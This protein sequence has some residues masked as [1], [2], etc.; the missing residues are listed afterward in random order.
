MNEKELK[1]LETVLNHPP[2]PGDIEQIEMAKDTFGYAFGSL[3]LLWCVMKDGGYILLPT[4][5]DWKTAER[6]ES[7]EENMWIRGVPLPV[8]T[9]V[10]FELLNAGG[11]VV[12]TRELQAKWNKLMAHPALNISALMLP[13]PY[14]EWR[15]VSLEQKV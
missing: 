3:D 6:P 15:L 14:E 13:E 12:L 9:Y 1:E 8:C 7:I 10:L 2:T 11:P 4:A 5:E